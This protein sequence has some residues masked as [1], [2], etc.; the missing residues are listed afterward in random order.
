M[1]QIDKY[2]LRTLL[3]VFFFGFLTV[4][5][6]A[7]TVVDPEIAFAPGFQERDIIVS[8]NNPK[9]AEMIKQGDAFYKQR[10]YRKAK[11]SYEQALAADPRMLGGHLK[12]CVAYLA[13]G[14]GREALSMARAE[15]KSNPNSAIAYNNSGYGLDQ[16]LLFDEAIEM[17]KKAIE[18]DPALSQSYLNLADSYESAG[19]LADE[20]K[21][22]PVFFAK[23]TAVLKDFLKIEPNNERAAAALV[24]VAMAGEQFDNAVSFGLEWVKINPGSFDA[25]YQLGTAYLQAGKPADAVFAFEK[26]SELKP[27]DL[28]SR[29]FLGIAL[30]MSGQRQKALEILTKNFPEQSRLFFG[31]GMTIFYAK[32]FGDAAEFLK[33]AVIAEPKFVNAIYQL[34]V[35]YSEMG[36]RQAALEQY[37]KLKKI[38]AEAAEELLRRIKR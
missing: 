11:E 33:Q 36:N 14:K 37:N 26:A 8:S 5:L 4:V 18:L 7:Q 24:R 38:D 30:A 13:L 21:L 29:R 12:L 3:S 1:K 9:A 16:F 6:N 19:R 20:E 25:Q 27:D 23:A 34:A 35:C 32:N 2:L 10:K 31:L 17:Y 15:L 22:K 28:Q